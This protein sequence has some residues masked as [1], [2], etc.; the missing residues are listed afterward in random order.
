[1]TPVRRPLAFA[2]C[3]FIALASSLF[4]SPSAAAVENE[5]FGLAPQDEENR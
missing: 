4:L 1:M 5:A 3:V 2:C